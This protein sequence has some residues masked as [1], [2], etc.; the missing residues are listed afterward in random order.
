[1]ISRILELET[2]PNNACP[3]ILDKVIHSIW[4]KCNEDRNMK[5]D[6]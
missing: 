1:M 6:G 4:L 3:V 5:R 2:K